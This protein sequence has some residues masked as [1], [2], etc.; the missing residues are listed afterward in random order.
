LQ[1]C[2]GRGEIADRGSCE[3]QRQ[4][5]PT[6]RAPSLFASSFRQ[7]FD[8]R[9]G[10]FEKSWAG[11]EAGPRATQVGAYPESLKTQH[12]ISHSPPVPKTNTGPLP[13]SRSIT[14]PGLLTHAD[15]ARYAS[16]N[17]NQN[18]NQ[19]Q[20]T[21]EFSRH[22]PSRKPVS[23]SVPRRA[24]SKTVLAEYKRSTSGNIKEDGPH[25]PSIRG[26]CYKTFYGRKLR[27]F[28]IS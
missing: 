22:P 3:R 17:Q 5:R 24:S 23:P 4:G 2:K 20:V 16:Q 26:Q 28:V 8:S 15:Q 6:Q 27:L 19:N 11:S 21:F 10:L 14:S 25:R 1:A 18:Q 13:L 7:V 9:R 12:S